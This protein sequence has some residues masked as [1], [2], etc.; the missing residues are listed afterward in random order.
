MTPSLLELQPRL[1]GE[2]H[3]RRLADPLDLDRGIAPPQGRQRLHVCSHELRRVT[4]THAGDAAEVI[5]GAPLVGADGIPATDATMLDGLGVGVLRPRRQ[6]SLE[7]GLDG[8]VV[9]LEIAY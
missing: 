5:I 7:S 6:A 2:A 1:A 3:A 8:P 9:R 4:P